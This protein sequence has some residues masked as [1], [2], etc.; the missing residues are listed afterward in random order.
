MKLRDLVQNIGRRLK[1]I[2]NR[3]ESYTQLQNKYATIMNWTNNHFQT[4]LSKTATQPLKPDRPSS[5]HPT[6][7]LWLPKVDL[8]MAY[9]LLLLHIQVGKEEVF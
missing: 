6:R 9:L 3:I 2:E 7:S 8:R 4:T 5:T 1:Q